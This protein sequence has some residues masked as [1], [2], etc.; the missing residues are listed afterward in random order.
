MLS[1]IISSRS[2]WNLHLE[3][4][5]K[6]IKDVMAGLTDSLKRLNMWMP[7]WQVNGKPRTNMASEVATT[8]YKV[9]VV[10]RFCLRVWC[11]ILTNLSKFQTFSLILC[12]KVVSMPLV[13]EVLESAIDRS[14]QWS[15]SQMPRKCCVTMWYII[16]LLSY[17]I[18][19]IFC[20]ENVSFSKDIFDER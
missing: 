2:S 9:V 13:C 7:P 20:G 14:V 6:R 15:P 12:E 1:I 5:G 19:C 17:I 11:K 8:T 18:Y 3:S 4:T 16:I 10:W